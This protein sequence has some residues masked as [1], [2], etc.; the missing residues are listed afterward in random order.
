MSYSLSSKPSRL[1]AFLADFKHT[2]TTITGLDLPIKAH[3]DDC[4]GCLGVSALAVGGDDDFYMLSEGEEY[5]LDFKVWGYFCIE[6][7]EFYL[8]VKDG[9]V[10]EIS[11]PGPG[12][13]ADEVSVE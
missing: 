5:P 7:C 8:R 12:A 3:G 6:G 1:S 9:E 13:I 2:K 4:V 11:I 10:S